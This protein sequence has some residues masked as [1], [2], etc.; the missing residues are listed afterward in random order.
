MANNARSFKAPQCE[1]PANVIEDDCPKFSLQQN[2]P[3]L[4][5]AQLALQPSSGSRQS[6]RQCTPRSWPLHPAS[7]A[8]TNSTNFASVWR[9]TKRNAFCVVDGEQ[10]STG[11]LTA[12]SAVAVLANGRFAA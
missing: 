9:L 10:R 2:P 11:C 3:D 8:A 7:R 5:V 6:R 12:H 4:V 1:K